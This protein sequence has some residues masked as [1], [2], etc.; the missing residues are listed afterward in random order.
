MADGQKDY[1]QG[2]IE[3]YQTRTNTKMTVASERLAVIAAATL[4]LTA[5]PSVPGMNVIVNTSTYWLA[6]TVLLV[7][8]LVMSAILLPWARRRDGGNTPASEHQQITHA[9]PSTARMPVSMVK[10]STEPSRI[11]QPGQPF[12]GPH[13]LGGM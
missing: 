1:L 9:G 5:L 4:P 7:V 2:V 10:P 3:S 12:A 13:S 8:M 6:L 11:S